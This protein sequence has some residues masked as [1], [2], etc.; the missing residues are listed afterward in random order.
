LDERAPTDTIYEDANVRVSKVVGKGY[1]MLAARRFEAGAL[2]LQVCA[3]ESV[4]LRASL[5][6]II[7]YI[8]IVINIIIIIYGSPHCE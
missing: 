7:I 5:T 8:T 4:R 6:V 2:V 3:R 1:G